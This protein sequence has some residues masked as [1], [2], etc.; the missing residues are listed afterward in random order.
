MNRQ[1][2][3]RLLLLAA[4]IGAPGFIQFDITGLTQDF[5]LINPN[6]LMRIAVYAVLGF[7]FLGI[8]AFPGAVLGMFSGAFLV[9]Y[10]KCQDIKKSLRAGV[11]SLVGRLGAIAA[12]VAICL[13]MIAIVLT[14]V[15]GA[16]GI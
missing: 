4:A 8:G 6:S 2:F 1:T 12:K 16:R 3:S 14:T 15:W 9:E 10:R 5:G 7:L 11:G 13:T